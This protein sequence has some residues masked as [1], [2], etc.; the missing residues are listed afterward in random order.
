MNFSNDKIQ[1][2]L[3][4]RNSAIEKYNREI[5]K[6]IDIENAKHYFSWKRFLCM[7]GLVLFIVFAF[8]INKKIFPKTSI[9][10]WRHY[11]Y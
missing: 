1:K 2:L 6:E 4:E 5:Q 8:E 10:G 11:G 9:W 7:I 3:S